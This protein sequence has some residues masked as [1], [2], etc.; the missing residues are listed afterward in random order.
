[1]IFHKLLGKYL[2]DFCNQVEMVMLHKTSYAYLI[3]YEVFLGPAG[4]EATIFLFYLRSQTSFF[5]RD[6]VSNKSES[7]Q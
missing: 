3:L 4:D 7:M 2:L 6:K 5:E 1:M